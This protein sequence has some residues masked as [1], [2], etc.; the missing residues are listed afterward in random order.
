MIDCGVTEENIKVKPSEAQDLTNAAYVITYDTPE[1]IED[2]IRRI[3]LK[4]PGVTDPHN[5]RTRKIGNR[6]SIDVHV[7]MDGNISLNEAHDK[8]KDI[9]H[10]IKNAIGQDTFV[11]IHVEPIKHPE[12]Q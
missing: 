1:E 4:C 12:C 11:M 8:T 7:R 3:I 10:H 2:E 5:L 6:K 9:E